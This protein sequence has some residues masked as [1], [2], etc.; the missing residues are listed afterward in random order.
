[1]TLASGC[2]SA[3][4]GA[5]PAGPLAIGVGA[6]PGHPGYESML[7]GLQLAVDRLNETKGAKFR[8]RPPDSGSTS[9][10]QV[11]QQLRDDP[12][13]IGVVGH[14]ESEN[15][16]EA[17]PVYADA[18]HE[19]KNA[20][21]AISPTAS[22]PRLSG[23][24]PWFFRVA[25][26]D[27]DAARFVARWVLDTLGARR[28]AVIYRNDSY[29]R[30]WSSTFSDTFIKAGAVVVA[31]HPY[32]TGLTEWDA[33]AQLLAKLKPDVLLFPG[34]AGDAVAMLR[35][36]RAANVSLTFIG[37]DGT[38]GM[39]DSSEAQGA[40]YVAFF[41]PDRIESDEGRTFARRYQ[42]KYR[43]APDMFAAMSYDAALA[44]GRS[45]IKG[46]RTRLA[47]RRALE[48]LGTAGSPALEGVAGPVAFEKNHD[49]ARRA[50]VI[51]T[52]G[53]AAGRR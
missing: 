10:V 35:A 31:R 38:E 42:E 49:I 18:E 1:M 13:V 4:P 2:R 53:A 6:I 26:S 24:S 22:S 15:S 20:V 7:H 43:Q 30:D 16:I 37:G 8:L 32:L 19:G 3:D 33:Y 23:I 11:A 46:A 25:P 40:H 12:S 52:V 45:V 14:P 44:I 36:L 39:R 28:A 51:S 50:V 34:D 5:S 21:V 47:V 17:V 48:R 9:A 27:D 29:G 41:H